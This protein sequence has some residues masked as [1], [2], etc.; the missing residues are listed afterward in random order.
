[1][2]TNS[3]AVLIS[4]TGVL[5]VV[6]DGKTYNVAKDHPNYNNILA[7]IRNSD[8]DDFA[9]L[10]DVAAS[11]RNFIAPSNGKVTLENGQ[12]CYNGAVLHNSIT[13]RIVSLM[14]KGFPVTP[15]LRFLENLMQNPSKRAVDE[16]YGF[17]EVGN[18]PI[19]EDGHFLAFKNVQ[20]DWY[21][22]R[23]NVNIK[24]IKGKVN[25]QGQIFNGVGE[26]IEIARNQVDE[27]KDRTC[28]DGL[29][30]CSQDYLQH[31]S[32]GSGTHTVIVKLN[33]RDVVSIPADYHDTKGR[34]CRYTVVAEL[35]GTPA[36][37]VGKDVVGD[38]DKKYDEGY[39]DGVQ[40]NAPKSK[41]PEYV[42]GYADGSDTVAPV[43]AKGATVKASNS[44]L[45]TKPSGHKFWNRHGAGGRFVKR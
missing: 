15:M 8:W 2:K 5:T 23:G 28:S 19:T 20:A 14:R 6:L 45:G 36:D 1:M 13:D 33:P 29:H 27:N 31:F 11:V 9:S 32:C 41:D 12:V 18:L 37:Y 42:E 30:F 43:Q 24:P 21:S 25:D 40:G 39:E 34:C 35:N 22:S 44:D 38:F 10:A 16:L 3:V 4:S 17:L 7:A 26:E